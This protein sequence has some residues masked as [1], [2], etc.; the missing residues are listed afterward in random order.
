MYLVIR[1]LDTYLYVKLRCLMIGKI[2]TSA[3]GN[4]LSEKSEAGS[5]LT[6]GVSC[7]SLRVHDS[8]RHYDISHFYGNKADFIKVTAQSIS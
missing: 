4:M 1:A 3:T 6:V 7:A 5:F 2:R 8:M